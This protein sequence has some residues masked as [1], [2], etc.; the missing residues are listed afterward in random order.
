MFKT[1]RDIY[2]PHLTP[3]QMGKAIPFAKE[4]DKLQIIA[5]HFRCTILKNVETGHKFIVSINVVPPKE[6][7]I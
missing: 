6:L 5:V 7:E 4:G 2:P 3:E 1:I